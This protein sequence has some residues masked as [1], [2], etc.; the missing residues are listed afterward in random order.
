MYFLK[1]FGAVSNQYSLIHSFIKYM[2]QH[3]DRNT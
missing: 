2:I 3:L 1:V